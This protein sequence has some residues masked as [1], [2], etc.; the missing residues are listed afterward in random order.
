MGATPMPFPHL[1]YRSYYANGQSGL[2][3]N[4]P[5]IRN[6]AADALTAA[7]ASGQINFRPYDNDRN[8]YV[9][10][11]IV[12][13]AGSGSEETGNVNDIWLAKWSFRRR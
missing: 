13:H 3:L 12:V 6:L 4:F 8:G 7:T 11:F 9:G 5:N 10:A 1:Y 2:G